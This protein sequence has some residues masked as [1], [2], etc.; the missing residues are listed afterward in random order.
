MLHFLPPSTYMEG[1]L[2]LSFPIRFCMFRF[3]P[4]ECKKAMMYSDQ[5]R[6]NYNVQIWS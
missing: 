3:G 5:G 6:L 4:R 2:C 1:G